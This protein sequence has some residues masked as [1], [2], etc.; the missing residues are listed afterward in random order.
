MTKG[1][2]VTLPFIARDKVED[3]I[4]RIAKEATI[5]IVKLD[6]AID[7]MV[8]REITDRQILNVLRRGER[9]SGVTWNTDKERGWKCT[10]RRITAGANVTVATKLVRR[11]K[12]TCLIVTVF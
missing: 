7:R 3:E 8:Q 12:T 10:F 5:D 6:H 9:I 11:D 1:N 4:R 2:I